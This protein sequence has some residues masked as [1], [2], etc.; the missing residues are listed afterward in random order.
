[1][2]PLEACPWAGLTHPFNVFKWQGATD[3][4]NYVSE[5]EFLN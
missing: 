1:M 3:G 4:M 2:K 5:Y